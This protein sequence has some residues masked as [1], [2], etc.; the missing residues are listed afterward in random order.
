MSTLNCSFNS[1]CELCGKQFV[2]HNEFVS[3]NELQKSSESENL[4]WVMSPTTHYGFFVAQVLLSSLHAHTGCD[5]NY[6]TCTL[7]F[8]VGCHGDH[9]LLLNYWPLVYDDFTTVINSIEDQRT[10]VTFM[11]L[12]RHRLDDFHHQHNGHTGGMHQGRNISM[13]IFSIPDSPQDS[14]VMDKNANQP[15]TQAVQVVKR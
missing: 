8:S 9:I 5:I 14:K 10:F 6:S 4:E 15:T 2:C 12:K 1:Q 3:S 11:T 13:H 7:S